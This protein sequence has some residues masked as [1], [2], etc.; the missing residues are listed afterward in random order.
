MIAAG[1]QAVVASDALTLLLHAVA[2]RAMLSGRRSPRD[3]GL[4]G[5]ILISAS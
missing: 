4:G 1:A 2:R 3:Y 5:T